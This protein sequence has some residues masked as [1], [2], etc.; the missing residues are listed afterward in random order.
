[1]S[2]DRDSA[3]P[4][5]RGAAAPIGVFDSGIGG[6]TVVRQLLASLP[7]EDVL[8]FGD[9]ARVPYGIKSKE[10]VTRFSR[11]NTQF[12]VR[13][14]IKML[15]VACNSASAMALESLRRE[16]ELPILGVIHPGA[17]AAVR[18]TRSGKVGVIGTQATVGSRAYDRAIAELDPR[19]EVY[20]RPCPLF[21]PLAEEG[22]IQGE[23]PERVAAE[24]L[25]PLLSA[26]IDTL[27]LGCTHYP[28]LEA[29]IQKV[30]G[31]GV[32]LIDTAVETVREVTELL[33]TEQLEHPAGT[34]PREVRR[35][36]FVSDVPAEFRKV[37]ERFLGRELESL[38]WVDQDDLPWYER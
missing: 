34:S 7:G 9:T 22:W 18:A 2:G 30:A 33:Q 20:S 3:G 36:Y 26:G 8:Y 14:G 13:R 5:T 38:V 12:L 16:F 24:Y 11:E 17:T 15:V 28:L 31:D 6:L 1:M 23:V 10:T 4:R 25:A 21:V 35:E 19:V 29:T 37:G 27:I 32:T